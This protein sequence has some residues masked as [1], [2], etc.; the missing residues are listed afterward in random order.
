MTENIPDIISKENLN[1]EILFAGLWVVEF[2]VLL[3]HNFSIINAVIEN[4]DLDLSNHLLPIIITIILVGI[5]LVIIKMQK[6][7]LGE[8]FFIIQIFYFLLFYILIWFFG[9]IFYPSIS[10]FINSFFL[11]GVGI[12]ATYDIFSTLLRSSKSFDKLTMLENSVQGKSLAMKYVHSQFKKL[13]ENIS[14]LTPENINEKVAMMLKQD[15]ERFR[16]LCKLQGLEIDDMD[17]LW[18]YCYDQTTEIRESLM[19]MLNDYLS[20]QLLDEEITEEFD[21]S[22]EIDTLLAKYADLEDNK[23]GKIE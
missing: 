10:I 19:K 11:L 22:S 21:L 18:Y 6:L 9:E 16:Q 5:Y 7:K 2:I 1:A 14:Q 12:W 15:L 17:V 20:K 4:K 8:G 23:I 13:K 3:I